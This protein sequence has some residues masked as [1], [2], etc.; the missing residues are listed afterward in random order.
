MTGVRLSAILAE[1]EA[2]SVYR[3]V[4]SE[5]PRPEVLAWDLGA[6]ETQVVTCALRHGATRAVVD[7]LEA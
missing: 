2:S 3:V 7:D 5:P 6:G 4:A 1:L